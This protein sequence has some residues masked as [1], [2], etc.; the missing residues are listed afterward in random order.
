MCGIC[1]IYNPD[2]LDNPAPRLQAMRDVMAS[3]GPDAA[4]L[5]CDDVVGFGHRRLSIIDL[6]DNA[7]QPMQDAGESVAI[8]YNGE[9][10][11]FVELRQAL[12]DKGLRFTTHSDT[13]VLLQGY[14]AW[15]LDGLLE[16]INGMFAFGL[17]DKSK[18]TLY[19]VR[20]RLGV[21]P[22]YHYRHNGVLY[23]A[24]DVK[25]ILR[26]LPQMPELDATAIDQLL[27]YYCLP[28]TMSIFRGVE[29]VKPGHYL[30]ITGARITDTS[31]W[32]L[33]FADKWHAPEA[34]YLEAID[35]LLRDAVRCRLR[36]D[37]PLGA[38]LSGG[39]DSSMVVALMAGLSPAPPRTFSIGFREQAFN[40][41]PYARLVAGRYSTRHEEIVV[42]PDVQ[43]DLLKIIWAFGEPFG[44][45]S[46]IPTYYVSQAAR[47][48]VTV[49]LSGDGGDEAFGGYATIGAM[50]ASEQWLGRLPDAGIALLG[51]LDRV[52]AAL[53]PAPLQKLATL[54]AYQGFARFNRG[55]ERRALFD[56]AMKQ[57]LY[58]PDLCAQLSELDGHRHNQQIFAACHGAD[59]TDRMLMHDYLT[60][61]PDDYLTKVDVASMQHGL[62]VRSPFLD[63]RIVK[64][65]ARI[66]SPAKLR[67]NNGKYL[68]KKLAYRYLPKENIERRK[69]GFGIPVGRW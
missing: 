41:L 9:I 47:Q 13:E 11:N 25:A 53:K 29:K 64:L 62:E 3:R 40:E 15:G 18:Q 32:R 54:A 37:V 58:T 63:Y 6:S 7:N 5:F 69:A 48:H 2:G 31:Y 66:P 14:R 28:Q 46:A 30:T 22:L 39:L 1:G 52:P 68:L 67:V 35:A 20:D 60:L 61:L 49:A 59:A 50:F 8:T 23:F 55:W 36:S 33:D 24:S 38:F 44:D 12:Q 51:R 34:E 42:E 27:H 56:R 21:K 26:A 57:A 43:A 17:W 16:R 10:Y 45:S 65:L 4:G 19:L